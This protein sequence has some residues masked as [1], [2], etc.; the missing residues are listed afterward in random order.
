M[1]NRYQTLLRT[2]ELYNQ[3]SEEQKEGVKR[4]LANVSVEQYPGV[5]ARKSQRCIDYKK[6]LL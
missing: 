5:V 3:L 4:T 6:E 2:R 1:N